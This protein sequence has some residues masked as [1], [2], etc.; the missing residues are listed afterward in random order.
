M[1]GLFPIRLVHTP[2][3]PLWCVHRDHL[4]PT[5]DPVDPPAVIEVIVH[6][7][8]LTGSTPSCTKEADSP[9]AALCQDGIGGPAG[10]HACG[11]RRDP[12]VAA[13]R[14]A[15]S[16]GAAETKLERSGVQK[17]VGGCVTSTLPRP[18]TES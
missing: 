8:T 15:A 6:F 13:F 14:L 12:A 1:R 11:D 4:D 5:G 2:N 7:P 18:V 16:G 10:A 3:R 9:L 17:S